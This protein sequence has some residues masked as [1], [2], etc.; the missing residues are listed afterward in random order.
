MA[1]PILGDL[2]GGRARGMDVLRLGAATLVIVTHSYA[3]TNNAEPL[4]R[5]GGPEFGDIAVA[6]F[7]A[8]SGF[9]GHRQLGLRSAPALVR[10]AAR[11]QNPSRSVGGAAPSTFVMGIVVTELPVT[12]YL[13]SLSTWRY[14]LERALVFSTRTRSA[15]VFTNNPVRLRRERIAL[16]PARRGRRLWGDAPAR[17]H[18]R[19]GAP[20]RARAARHARA[21]RQYRRPCSRRRPASVRPRPATC[22]AGSCISA[23]STRSGR[24]CSS[25]ASCVP[26]S[27]VAAL[28]GLALWVVSFGTGAMTVVGQ[29]T[30]PYA[31]LVFGYRGPEIVDRVMRRIGDISYGTYIYAFPVQQ[32][33]IHYDTGIDPVTLTAYTVPI[34][35]AC[36]F[37]SWR[38]VERPALR[39]RRRLTREPDG[40]PRAAVVPPAP[41]HAGRRELLAAHARRVLPP[42]YPTSPY[43]VCDASSR[44]D[45]AARRRSGGARLLRGL[46]RVPAGGGARGGLSGRDR[47]LARCHRGDRLTARRPSPAGARSLV[48][49]PASCSARCA[50]RRADSARARWVPTNRFRWPPR[51]PWGSP[52]TLR[53]T[54][55]P[56]APRLRTS[57]PVA[58]RG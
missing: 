40:A 32:T 11:A 23:S 33:I 15:G 31:V 44:D 49:S 56:T 53:A 30:L 54:S 16:D 9:P 3:L 10:T 28:A 39:L 38:L 24:F 48:A 52:A 26:L 58:T 46:G 29:L 14:P 36:A 2:T 43:Y 37:L 18:R 51:R 20:A 1:L 35:Y 6:I 7:F 41:A 57:R 27:F 22:C 34:T 50:S 5:F 21:V 47:R 25:T 12:S 19:A 17:R 45:R 4:R 55:R 13:T 42:R 8:I